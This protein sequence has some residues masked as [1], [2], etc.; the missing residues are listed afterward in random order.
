MRKRIV[1][2]KGR[3]VRV[4]RMDSLGRREWKVLLEQENI[5]VFN[6]EHLKVSSK[7]LFTS[8]SP[9]FCAKLI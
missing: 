2:K 8:C 7:S 3:E 1:H 9:S 4:E 6:N 5:L